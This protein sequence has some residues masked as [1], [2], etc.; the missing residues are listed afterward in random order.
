[1]LFRR[2]KEL[3]EAQKDAVSAIDRLMKQ[4]ARARLYDRIMET[5]QTLDALYSQKKWC[6]KD[7]LEAA[8]KDRD[9]AY[10]DLIEFDLESRHVPKLIGP[11]SPTNDW[12]SS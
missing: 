9:Q 10:A 8:R 11:P 5:H 12:R 4:V 1:M 3:L 2:W 6:P 7:K